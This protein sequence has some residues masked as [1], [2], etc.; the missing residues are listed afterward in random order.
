MNHLNDKFELHYKEEFF[1]EISK[2]YKK[3]T[4]K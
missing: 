2:I 4:W 1:D 3:K